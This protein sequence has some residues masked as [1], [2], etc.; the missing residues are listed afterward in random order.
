MR[1]E[2]GRWLFTKVVEKE[3]IKEFSNKMESNSP[4]GCCSLK[5]GPSFDLLRLNTQL[6]WRACLII[7]LAP[8]AQTRSFFCSAS[9]CISIS[10]FLKM[11][12]KSGGIKLQQHV[13]SDWE[14]LPKVK[15]AHFSIIP[16]TFLPSLF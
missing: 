16:R 1:P 6:H 2:V 9:A 7:Y 11:M 8:G 3:L 12:E 10:V 14:K 13:L 15:G 5:C 4:C